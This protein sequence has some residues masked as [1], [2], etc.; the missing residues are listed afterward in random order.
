MKKLGVAIIGTGMMGQI[1]ARAARL[2][3]A[4]VRGIAASTPDSAARAAEA[5]GAERAFASADDAFADPSVDVVHVCTPNATHFQ[6]ALDALNAGKHVVCEKP[7]ATSVAD[8]SRLASA[9][10][11]AGKVATVPFVYRYHPMVREAKALID[12]GAVGAL[13]LIHGSYLQD[14]LLGAGDTNWRVHSALGGPSRAFADIGSHW[15]DLVEWVTGERFVSVVAALQTTIAERPTGTV[16][17]FSQATPT[18]TETQAV[19]T[20]DVACAV[21][22]SG[23]GVLANLTVSQVSAG[24]KN[25]LWFEVD[26]ADSSV[27]FDQEEPER[28]WVGLRDHTRLLVRDPSRGSA[29]QRRLATLPAGHAQGYSQCFEAFVA[30]TYAAIGGELRA[31]LPTFDDGLRSASIVEAVLD[32]SKQSAWTPIRAFT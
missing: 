19:T 9:A 26:G 2:A 11:S 8:A 30:D 22:R 31:G 18:V 10:A 4:T 24:R 21:F 16:K 27:V 6:L 29:E 7:L 13:Q 3:G 32:S 14:W 17:T 1:H 23:N 5:L 28:L 15:C 25:R 20:E 12:S